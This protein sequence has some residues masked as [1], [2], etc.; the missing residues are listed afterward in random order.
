MRFLLDT[1]AFLW[2]VEGAG[3]PSRVVEIVRA[4]EHELY[5]SAV[6]SWEIATK[7]SLGK[8]GLAESPERLVPEER[9]KHHIAALPLD[10][11]SALQVARLPRLHRDPFDRLLV[12]QAIVHGLTILTPDSDIAKYHIVRSGRSTRQASVVCFCHICA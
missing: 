10:E 3:L 5:L 7:Y 8:L 4:P 2:V 12:A 6:S 11:E 9:E 1:C